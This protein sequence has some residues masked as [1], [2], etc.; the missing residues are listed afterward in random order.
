MPVPVAATR[1]ERGGERTCLRR[2]RGGRR[3][4]RRQRRSFANPTPPAAIA[5]SG[6]AGATAAGPASAEG[7]CAEGSANATPITPTIWLV[8]DGSSSMETDF[9]PGVSRWDALRA[10]LMGPAGVVASLSM[11]RG[12]GSSSTAAAG[13]SWASACN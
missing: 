2:N 6:A 5:G 9:E 8:V 4:E 1:R 10:T 12:S 11:S 3:D 13:C 7:A